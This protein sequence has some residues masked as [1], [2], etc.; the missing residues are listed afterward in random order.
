MMNLPADQQE[1]LYGH[2]THLFL[3]F[4]MTVSKKTISNYMDTAGLL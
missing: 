2:V 3:Y 1:S 4:N